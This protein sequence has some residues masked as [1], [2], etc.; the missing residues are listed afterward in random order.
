MTSILLTTGLQECQTN[1]H[2]HGDQLELTEQYDGNCNQYHEHMMVS[3]ERQKSY[4]ARL[5]SCH[6]TD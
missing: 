1:V 4:P 5:K 6:P 2:L 3:Q